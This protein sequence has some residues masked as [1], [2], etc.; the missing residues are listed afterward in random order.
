MK[1]GA[2]KKHLEGEKRFDYFDSKTE[3]WILSHANHLPLYK[4]NF[5]KYLDF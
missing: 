3:F 2:Y 5:E 1:E 4:E